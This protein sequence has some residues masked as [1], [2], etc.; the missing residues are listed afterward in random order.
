MKHDL[1]QVLRRL[2]DLCFHNLALKLLSLLFAVMLWSYVVS[3]DNEITR[4]RRLNGLTGYVTGQATLEICDLALLT[5]PTDA[6][7]N[8]SVQ[9]Q[10]PQANYSQVGP[11]NV[12]VTLDL[13]SVR[14]AGTREIPLKAVSTYGKVLSIYPSSLTLTFET[15]DSRSVPMS[16]RFTGDS[17]DYWYSCSRMNPQ[18][19]SVSGATSLVRSVAG[20]VVDVDVTERET[21]FY[22]SGNVRLLDSEGETISTTM[23]NRSASSASMTVEVWPVKE[24]EISTDPNDVLIGQAAEGYDITSVTIQPSTVTVAA[25]KDLLDALDR[26]VIDPVEIDQPDRSF[27]KKTTVSGL[28]DFKYI[29]SEQVYVTVQ[30]EE[31]QISTWMTGIPVTFVG[32]TDSLIFSSPVTKVAVYV[33]GPRSEV[34]HLNPQDISAVCDLTGLGPGSHTLPLTVDGSNHPE[35]TLEA[36][37]ALIQVTVEEIGT[38]IEAEGGDRS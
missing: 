7:S 10:V 26:L 8:V 9:L 22:P 36:D 34:E 13:S 20:A 12:Q 2:K 30:I 33:T 28:S 27:T 32:R 5:D 23:I 6:L 17:E 29:S 35:L 18:S 4:V 1:K 37:T 21:T 14:T 16:V 25:E 31:E 19:I 24:L 15:L 3:S 11:E 38:D